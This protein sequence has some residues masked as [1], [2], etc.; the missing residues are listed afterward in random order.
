MGYVFISFLIALLDLF[1]KKM[2]KDHLTIGVKKEV[3]KDKFYLWHVKNPGIAFS[4]FKDKPGEILI[5]TGVLFLA[6]AGLFLGVL[7]KSESPAYKLALSFV[8]GG[9]FGNFYDRA[10]NR[11]VTDFLYVNKKYAPIFNIADIFIT[12]GGIIVCVFS[13]I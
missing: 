8:T 7:K 9:A 6:F 4:K 13:L 5:I 10:R 12:F 2:A 1:T 3:I 11:E